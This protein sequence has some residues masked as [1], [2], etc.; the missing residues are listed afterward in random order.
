MAAMLKLDF[1]WKEEGEMRRGD[2]RDAASS[3]LAR[4]SIL[5]SWMEEESTSLSWAYPLLAYRKAAE[6]ELG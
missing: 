3:L 1:W 6:K 2:I 4:P 5:S